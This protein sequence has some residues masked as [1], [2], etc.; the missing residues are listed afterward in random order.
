M[1]E[2]AATGDGNERPGRPGATCGS[3]PLNRLTLRGGRY[4]V[5][6]GQMARGS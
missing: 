3:D 4:K 5:R 1:K 6:G 2:P